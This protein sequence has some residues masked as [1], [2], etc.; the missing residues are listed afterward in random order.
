MRPMRHGHRESPGIGFERRTTLTTEINET[1]RN[2]DINEPTH[3]TEMLSGDVWIIVAILYQF[4]IVS[5]I[6]GCRLPASARK[7]RLVPV[8]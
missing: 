5:V 1:I 8:G 7:I 4:R 6:E 3:K 2:S